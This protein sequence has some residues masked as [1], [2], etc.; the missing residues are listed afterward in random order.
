[1]AKALL[2]AWSA[3]DRGRFTHTW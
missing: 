2:T 1:L 3:W